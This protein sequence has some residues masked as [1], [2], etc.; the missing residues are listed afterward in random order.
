MTTAFFETYGFARS[1]VTLHNW[2]TA[3]YS[4]WSF[5]NLRE[6]VPTAEI[7]CTAV[8]TEIALD[9]SDLMGTA[10]V[11]AGASDGTV[12]GF[13]ELTD[14]DAFVLMHKG[15]VVAEHY[16]PSSGVNAKHL[17]FSIS[18]SI[19]GLL[20]GILET[21]GLVDPD[22]PVVHYMPEAAGSAYGDCTVRHVLDMRVNLDFTE[23]YLNMDGDFARYRRSTLWNP[24]MDGKPAETMTEV[25]LSLPKAEGPH[26]G[27]FF[28]ASPNSDLLGVLVER[29][30]NRRLPDLVSDHI[31][32]PA[33]ALNNASVS[34]DRVGAARAAG[35]MS[36]TARD[37]ARIGEMLRLG[38]AVDG[39]QVVPE[40]WIADMLNNGDHEAWA[41]GSS[42]PMP[43]GRYR[44]KWYQTGADDG[45]FCG[46]G[47]HGQWI[48][49]DPMRETVMVK[50][51]SQ[52]GPLDD[53]MKYDNV[54]FFQAVSRLTA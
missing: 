20:C 13:L 18:K 29:V 52:P 19:T 31:W 43:N 23:D 46:I 36:V 24:P 33:G 34:V 10:I 2:R 5:Q 35:G 12:R 9:P 6:L 16:A 53:D 39:R 49:V 15:A 47:I 1:D 42:I 7:A 25:L 50:F 38:G 32:K 21:E 22:R 3:P 30:S 4:R 48:Y 8:Q 45:A 27:P 37:L 54:G 44:S 28:Y 40:R 17:I 41:A 26:G 14:T 11:P 51:S